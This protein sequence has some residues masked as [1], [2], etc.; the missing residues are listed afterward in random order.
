MTKPW[1]HEGKFTKERTFQFNVFLVPFYYYFVSFCF[2]IYLTFTA[3]QNKG[4]NEEKKV[5]EDVVTKNIIFPIGRK[6]NLL[7][8]NRSS[9]FPYPLD[10]KGGNFTTPNRKEG[11]RVT[12]TGI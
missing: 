1:L 12:V 5:V 3:I 10:K 11:M 8:H 6:L 7:H 2:P 9:R 4:I